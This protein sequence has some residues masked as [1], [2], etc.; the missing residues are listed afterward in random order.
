[1]KKLAK[2][3]T[4]RSH[5]SL[6]LIPSI[7]KI[8]VLIAVFLTHYLTGFTICIKID[9]FKKISYSNQAHLTATTSNRVPVLS[10]ICRFMSVS[11][12]NHASV[13]VLNTCACREEERTSPYANML[14]SVFFSSWKKLLA[15]LNQIYWKELGT[16]LTTVFQQ[17]FYPGPYPKCAKD[18]G[19]SSADLCN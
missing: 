19:S 11:W 17:A 12:H 18:H 10:E 4:A 6:S 16:H 7:R 2:S 14:L 3:T 13:S 5:P 9:F 8:E 15:Q 1:M